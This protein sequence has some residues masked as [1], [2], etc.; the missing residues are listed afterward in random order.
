[1]AARRKARYVGFTL[2]ELLVVIGII[3][4]LIGLLLPAVQKVREAAARAKSM[5][6]LKQIN[7]ATQHYATSNADHLPSINGFNFHSLRFECS[8]MIGLMPYIEEGNLYRAYQ[9]H[10]GPGG[11]GS[12]YVVKPYISPADPTLRDPPAAIASY[13]ANAIAFAPRSRLSTTFDDGTSNTIGY[14]EH[15]SDICGTRA[16]YWAERD[17]MPF[18][19]GYDGPRSRRATFADKMMGDVVPVTEGVSAVSRGSVAGLTFQVRPQVGDC[20][21]RVAQTPHAG[22]M[23]VALMDGSVRTLA[24]GM[25]ETTYWSAVTPAGGEALGSDW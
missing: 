3:A 22:G 21:P 25:T 18:F 10:F 24:P 17:Q 14:A 4:V 20:D 7:L 2:I 9:E 6:N 19:P 13:A 5:N 1:M 11:W 12:E 15:Y 8:L 16:F 23:I